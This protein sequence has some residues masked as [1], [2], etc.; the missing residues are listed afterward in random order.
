MSS[1]ANAGRIEAFWTSVDPEVRND[2]SDEQ[3]DAIWTAVNRRSEEEFPADVRLSLGG[4]FLVVLFG[5]ERRAT[6]RLAEERR[7]RP[8]FTSRNLPLIV[9]MW[10]SVLYTGYSL[11]TGSLKAILL[12]MF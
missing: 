5:R 9:I 6:E 2:L 4:Y 3:K 8:V 12:S 7:R 10:G 11:L 1:Q